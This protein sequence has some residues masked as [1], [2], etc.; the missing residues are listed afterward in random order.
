MRIKIPQRC[1][2]EGL[3]QCTISHAYETDFPTAITGAGWYRMQQGAPAEL[4]PQWDIDQESWCGVFPPNKSI[5]ILLA[6]EYCG[7]SAGAQA[8][9]K[10]GST[11]KAPKVYI[12]ALAVDQRCLG[13]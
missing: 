13:V 11:R 4:D 3:T 1:L 5:Q 9:A 12:S 8:G 2:T 7:G 10:S 6:I